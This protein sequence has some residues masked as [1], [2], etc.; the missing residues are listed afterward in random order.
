MTLRRIQLIRCAEYACVC[1]CKQT[2]HLSGFE[3]ITCTQ[4]VKYTVYQVYTSF[5]WLFQ[6]IT[7]QRS[8]LGFQFEAIHKFR[9]GN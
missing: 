1:V 5:S 3:F 8:G 6:Q 9:M 4:G 2:M 7:Y